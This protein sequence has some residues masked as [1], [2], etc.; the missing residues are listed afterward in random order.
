M[1]LPHVFDDTYIKDRMRE[2]ILKRRRVSF[3]DEN[4]VLRRIGFFKRLEY[5]A[6]DLVDWW[7]LS[8]DRKYLENLID[9][10][11]YFLANFKNVTEFS[12]FLKTMKELELEGIVFRTSRIFFVDFG[13]CKDWECM[14]RSF[15]KNIWKNV[16]HFRNVLKR[17]Y[18]SWKIEKMKALETKDFLFMVEV[19]RRRFRNPYFED[20]DYLR[21]LAKILDYFS[22]RGEL[23]VW[24]LRA[25]KDPLCI[26]VVIERDGFALSYMTAFLENTDAYR[27]LMFN[28]MKQYF[29]ENFVQFNFMKGES[30]YKQ[31][32]TE[33]FYTLYRFSFKHPNAIKRW[34]SVLTI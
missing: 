11:L 7:D 6:Q 19:I 10:N 31:Q 3:I 23:S 21:M 8:V 30:S 33:D 20:E 1:Y 32:W 5:F 22:Q 2:Y 24:I 28:M 26:N 34:L 12:N 18:K 4:F 27:F 16:R 13:K 25:E 15:S 29:E 14:R 17:R 9:S